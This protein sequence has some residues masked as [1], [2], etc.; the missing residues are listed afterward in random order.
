MFEYKESKKITDQ[1]DGE[2]IKRDEN[3]HKYATD[4][5]IEI[6]DKV[7]E[8]EDDINVTS[9]GENLLYHSIHFLKARGWSEEQLLESVKTHY[10]LYDGEPEALEE[11]S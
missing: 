5:F 10:H 7:S 8:Q 4:N 3:S 6:L 9:V 1:I 11:K 2:L